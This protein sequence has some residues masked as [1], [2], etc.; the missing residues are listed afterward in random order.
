MDIAFNA[1]ALLFLF[2]V[3]GG[4][5]GLVVRNIKYVASA[6]HI[7]LFAFG[8]VL[9]L[10]TTLP[11]LSVGINA[12]IDG[13]A[14]LSV[15]NLLSGIIVI[16]GLILGTSL[17]IDRRIRSGGRL[18][19]LIPEVLVM[20]SPVLFGLDGRYGL[21]DG[22]AMTGLYIVLIFYLY[23][24]N[25]S[26]GFSRPQILHTK[27]IATALLFSILGI[28][29]ILLSSHWIVEV[30][31]GLLDKTHINKL[32]IGALV[33]AIGTNLPEITIAI[34]SWRKRASGLSLSHL[35][36]SAFTNVL[37]LGVL[38]IMRPITFTVGPAFWTIAVFLAAILFLFV[39]F[40]ASGKKMDRREG[41]ILVVIYVAF[42][43]VN[44]W[45]LD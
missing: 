9:G 12:T 30:T 24:A 3:L 33:F 18:A 35:I 39:L 31:I 40:Y 34:T 14:A 22:L 42:L 36:S 21:W 41:L 13:V 37:V 38:T 4:S 7:K 26:F 10:I 28:V 23:R 2:V 45:L 11:E 44:M 32:V 15:G 8:I 27:K 16:F 17:L 19:I 20:F 29:F 25:H 1:V 43:I 6:L 5:A